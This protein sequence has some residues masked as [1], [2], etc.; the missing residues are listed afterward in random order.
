M[1][2]I[3]EERFNDGIQESNYLLKSAIN[4][5]N[6]DMEY[7]QEITESVNDYR[8]EDLLYTEASVNFASKV[9]EAFVKIIEAIKK[10]ITDSKRAIKTKMAQLKINMQLNK[11]KKKMDALSE[12]G[13][14]IDD[15]VVK[16]NKNNVSKA[17][18]TTK[19]IVERYKKYCSVAVELASK[20]SYCT[21]SEFERLKTKMD[22]V[23]KIYV[24]K[25]TTCINDYFSLVAHVGEAYNEVIEEF[26]KLAD[27]L[28]EVLS[29][30][31]DAEKRLMDEAEKAA[32]DEVENEKNAKKAKRIAFI[33]MVGNKIA[34][35]SKTVANAVQK[36]PFV[37][38]SALS[39]TIAGISIG[40]VVKNK[41]SGK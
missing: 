1:F 30:I 13:I 32:K 4:A 20:A 18:V 40:A 25:I 16:L 6:S 41:K 21:D 26:N 11:L 28:D 37:A 36:H 38:I 5:Y 10:F 24:D 17:K 8:I 19:M 14:D 31:H 29:I 7:T 39:A 15:T 22:N 9:K 35:A 34:T 2:K 33:K 3:I 23:D 12:A 27:T